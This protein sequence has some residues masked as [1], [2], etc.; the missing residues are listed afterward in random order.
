MT[1]WTRERVISI[2]ELVMGCGILI[3]W[4]LFFTVGL[5]PAGAP[6]CYLAFEH[7]FPL[8][9]TMLALALIAAGFLLARG[10]ALG[11]PLSFACA[12]ALIFLGLLDFS[13]GLLNGLLVGAALNAIADTAINILL[14][15]SGAAIFAGL[16]QRLQTSQV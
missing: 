4:V 16:K 2:L 7:S 6:A 1:P 13:F 12:G 14:V 8:P 9:D 10:G 11:R 15:F 3:Y 5:V